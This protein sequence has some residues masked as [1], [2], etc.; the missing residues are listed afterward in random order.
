MTDEAN[1]PIVVALGG[2]ALADVISNMDSDVLSE[3]SKTLAKHAKAGLVITHGNGPQIGILA[4]PRRSNTAPSLDVLN[5]QTEGW[6]GY[7]IEQ[8]LSAHVDAQQAIAT[9]LTRVEVDLD[10]SDSLKPR[11]PIGRW[12][13]QTKAE[14]LRRDFNWRFTERNGKYRRLVPSP[15]PSRCL[16]IAAIDTLLHHGHIVICA[17]GGGIPVT[18]DS[19]GN[20]TGMEAVIDKDLATSLIA[21]QL[22]A[23]LL[24]L[25]TNVPGI[26]D[27]WPL[28]PQKASDISPIDQ[29]AATDLL[30][31][32]FESGSMGPKALAAGLFTRSTGQ[33]SVIGDLGD[34]D[35]LIALTA[36]TRITH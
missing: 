22:D 29:I 16:Q 26:Y 17:G 25:A 33:P 10:K 23:R 14:A 21:R 36:G 18:R 35:K 5:A 27:S 24:V 12:L 32:Q 1:G 3:A 30:D 4:E 20:L 7:E 15:E 28:R 13:D 11:K 31:R 2:N 19:H 34:L 6:L 8:Q 9:L